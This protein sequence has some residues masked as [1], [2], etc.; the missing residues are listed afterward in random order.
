MQFVV[1]ILFE[2]LKCLRVDSRTPLSLIF[3][4]SLLLLLCLGLN[5]L[6]VVVHRLVELHIFSQILQIFLE[7]VRPSNSNIMFSFGLTVILLDSFSIGSYEFVESGKVE[8]FVDEH[9]ID[10]TNL[11]LELVN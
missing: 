7:L 11:L 6:V 3:H 8:V 10:F 9:I 4:L 5:F 1:K 2:V